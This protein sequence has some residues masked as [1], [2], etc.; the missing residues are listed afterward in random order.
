MFIGDVMLIVM[1]PLLVDSMAKMK[2]FQVRR[3]S[4]IGRLDVVE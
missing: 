1:S 3:I 4:R 2:M